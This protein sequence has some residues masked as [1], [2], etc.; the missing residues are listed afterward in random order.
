MVTENEYKSIIEYVRDELRKQLL[1]ATYDNGYPAKVV[2]QATIES[3]PSLCKYSEW[4]EVKRPKNKKE[5]ISQE[6]QDA[7][8][9]WWS[10]Y[11]GIS[12]FT[13]KDKK[14][15]GERVL[16]ANKQKCLKLYADITGEKTIHGWVGKP[17]GTLL[18]ALLVQLENIKIESYKTGQNRM[19]YLKSAEV[20]LNQKAYEPWI[21]EEMP[22]Q[23]KEVKIVQN[24]TDL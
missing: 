6:V 13:Y 14:F 20:Y 4:K 11:P 19:Q 15:P 10:Q 1:M 3:L 2:P 23:I 21:G 7:F 17:P 22:E 12:R 24:S 5:G 9:I 16:K 8:E 18:N